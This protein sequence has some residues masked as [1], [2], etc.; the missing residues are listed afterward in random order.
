MSKVH[1]LAI[2]L[3]AAS[4][5][6]CLG[7]EVGE[8]PTKTQSTEEE[9]TKPAENNDNETNDIDELVSEI[10]N[11]TDEIEELNNQIDVLSEDLQSLETY[12]YNPLEN[13][14]VSMFHENGQYTNFSKRGNE[15]HVNLSHNMGSHVWFLDNNGIVIKMG[16]LK[17]ISDRCNYNNTWYPITNQ[18][19]CGGQTSIINYQINLVREPVTVYVGYPNSHQRVESFP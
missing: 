6:G 10:Q 3:L 15:I 8:E 14:T 16:E 13:S 1:I 2:C 9:T 19:V 11:L 12:R 5:T 7:G 17:V 18:T 4:F